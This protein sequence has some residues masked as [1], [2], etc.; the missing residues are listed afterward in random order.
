MWYPIESEHAAAPPREDMLRAIY[1]MRRPDGV[2]GMYGVSRI[3]LLSMD[4][5]TDAIIVGW[6][7]VN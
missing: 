4:P 7:S 2:K 6:N 5:D 1:C 3:R